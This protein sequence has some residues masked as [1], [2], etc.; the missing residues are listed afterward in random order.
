M[1]AIDKKN[2]QKVF[3]L[4]LLFRVTIDNS[5]AI[6]A[7]PPNDLNQ[8]LPELYNNLIFSLLEAKIFTRYNKPM[9]AVIILYMLYYACNKRSNLLQ[10]ANS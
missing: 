2:W 5:D 7:D 4:W 8:K 6:I 3:F 9:I 1:V 10:T